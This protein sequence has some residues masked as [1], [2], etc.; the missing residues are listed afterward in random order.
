MANA[1]LAERDLDERVALARRTVETRQDSF[2]IFSRRLEVGSASRLELTQV[3]TLLSQAQILLSQLEQ[4]RAAQ[5]HALALLLG[6]DPG[7]LPD[8]PP[9]DEDAEVFQ[10]ETGGH[11]TPPDRE[12][13]VVGRHRVLAC[14]VLE[15]L[16]VF[17]A[18]SRFSPCLCG[19]V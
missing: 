2:R 9:F 12:Q 15:L 19:S 8:A 11:G 10:T 14:L 4:A 7:P 3:H 17:V 5:T 16:R 18:C 13:D 6:A 1:Y